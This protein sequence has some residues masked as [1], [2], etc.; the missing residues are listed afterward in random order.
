MNIE[1]Q[2]IEIRDIINQVKENTYRV[3]NEELFSP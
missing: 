2:F 3:V 1:R